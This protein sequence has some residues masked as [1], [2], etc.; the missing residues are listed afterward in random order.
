M[1][2]KLLEGEYSG[3]MKHVAR[4]DFTK[5][6]QIKTFIEWCKDK[7]FL[8]N[9][10]YSDLI[11]FYKS[12]DHIDLPILR[13]NG[14][15]IGIRSTKDVFVVGID[16]LRDFTSVSKASIIMNFPITSKREAKKFYNMLEDLLDKNT[17]RSKDWRREAGSMWCGAYLFN[18]S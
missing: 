9:L 5:D 8:D 17:Q 15:G 7:G 2:R 16:P 4:C 18:A 3:I 6:G 12:N 11:D 13:Y 10:D 1:K 14:I